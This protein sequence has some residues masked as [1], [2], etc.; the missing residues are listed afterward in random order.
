MYKI[1]KLT[2]VGGGSTYTPE[3]LS[4][5]I[6]HREKLAV[7][8]I[9]LFDINR[10]RLETVGGL[11]SRMLQRAELDTRLE[12]TQNRTG[13]LEGADFIVSQIR[14]GLMPARILDERIPFSHGVLGQETVGAGGL[15]NAFR[16]IPVSLEIAREAARYAPDAWYLNFTN[17]SGII[18]EALLNHSE[19]KRV[20]GLC[21][22]PIN[23]QRAVAELLNVPSQKVWLDW[24]GLNHLGWIRGIY[25]DGRDRLPEVIERLSQQLSDEASE[26]FPFESRLLHDLGLLPTY[27]LRYY[28]ATQNAISEVQKAGKTRGEVVLDIERDL[29]GRYADPNQVIKP[30]ELKQRGGAYYSEAAIRLILSLLSDRRDVQI[31]ITRNNGAIQGLP[32]HVSVEVPSIVGAHGISPLSCGKPPAQVKH[33]LESVK[34]SESLAVEAGVSGSRRKAVM[35]LVANPLVPGF[36]LAERLTDELL[37]AHRRYLPQF[38]SSEE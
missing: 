36:E 32:D 28:Y 33:L 5:F 12:L 23:A 13:A 38:F 4:G 29:L 19:L 14:V 7:D 27:Y 1:Q 35:A 24:I 25:V 9:S 37:E 2:V 10:E 16:T 15:F 8:R 17:P 34:A 21:N 3:L 26:R 20:A 31:L 18:T 30:E 22:V 6:E 11:V